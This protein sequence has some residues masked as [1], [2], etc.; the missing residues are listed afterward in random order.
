MKR[1][2]SSTKNNSSKTKYTIR[3]DNV[4][5]EDTETFKFRGADFTSKIKIISDPKEPFIKET[6][7]EK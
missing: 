1:T 4:I 3:K 6:I 5:F 2:K 7:K